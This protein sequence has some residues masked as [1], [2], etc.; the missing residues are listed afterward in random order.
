MYVLTTVGNSRVYIST[1]IHDV[2]RIRIIA[3]IGF[4]FFTGG[5]YNVNYESTL[6]FLS[7]F[8]RLMDAYLN[9]VLS[10]CEVI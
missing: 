6:I 1:K 5:R 10:Y 4:L 2:K 8:C 9:H 3:V 7:F